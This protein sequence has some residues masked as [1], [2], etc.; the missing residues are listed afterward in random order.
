M[1]TRDSHSNGI[2]LVS[3]HR[4]RWWLQPSLLLVVATFACGGDDAGA[5]TGA[6]DA[7]AVVVLQPTDIATARI[8]TVAEG[9]VL[10]GTLNPYRIAEVRAQVPGLVS[11]IRVDRGDA[12]GAGQVMAVLDAQGIR[13]SAAGARAQV[14]AAEANLALARQ[15]YESSRKLYEAGAVSQIDYQAA[16]AG[17]EAARGQLAAAQAAA[18]GASESARQATITA[19]F[20]GEVSSRAVNVGEAVSPGQALFTIVN[21]TAL[22]LAGHIPV[23]QA[24]LVQ[25]GQAVEFSLDAYPGRVFV[26]EVERVEPMANPD[27]RRVGVYLRMPNTG[28]TLVG[29][30]FATGRIVTGAQDSVLVVPATAVRESDGGTYVWAVEN[31]RLVQR[32]VTVGSTDPARNTASILSGLQ[33]GDRVLVA[34]GEPAPDARIRMGG[35]PTASPQET[36]DGHE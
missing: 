26:G 24:A 2:S 31:D 16:Q 22:E 9:V 19:P 23:Q 14:A 15:R 21:S 8:E 13:S 6:E 27:T 12:V 30:L 33:P 17:L 1:T 10:T 36:E 25:R 18:A 7:E 34:P 4:T 29:G 32:G 5:E 3:T 35:V 11:S 28:R 20:A